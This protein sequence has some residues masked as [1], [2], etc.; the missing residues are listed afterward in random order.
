[1][2]SLNFSALHEYDAGLDGV[3]VWVGL[4]TGGVAVTTSAKLDTGCT[5]CIFQ[6]QIAERLKLDVESGEEQ[7][8]HSVHGKTVTYGHFV[9][10]SVEE[11]YFDTMVYFAADEFFPRN[12]LGRR[13]FLNQIKM[14]LIDY[15]GALYLS[16][17]GE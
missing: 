1:M 5:A 11:L 6:R 13:G 9:T 8:F 2:H 14:G 3:T 4:E 16:R 12:L 17:Y 15:D 10:L 7:I